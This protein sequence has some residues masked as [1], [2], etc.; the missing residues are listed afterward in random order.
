MKAIDL[1]SVV[2][3]NKI[4]LYISYSFIFHY[5]YYGFMYEFIYIWKHISYVELLS[6]GNSQIHG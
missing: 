4:L 6:D 1:M 2:F 3:Y 5:I